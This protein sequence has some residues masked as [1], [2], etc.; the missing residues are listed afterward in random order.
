MGDRQKTKQQLLEELA[1]LRLEIAALKQQRAVPLSPQDVQSQAMTE[2][3]QIKQ[4]LELHAIVIRNIAEGICLVRACDGIIVYANP[5]FE[6]MFGYG[7]EEL[8]GQHVSIV[9]YAPDQATAEAVNQTI[10]QAVTQNGEAIYEVHNV[11]KDGTPFWC[12]AI[13]SAFEHPE[14]GPVFVAVQQDITAQRQAEEKLR[15]SLREKEVLLKE[16]H[17]RV[18]NNLQIVDSLLT[19]QARRTDDPR[20]RSI[21]RD[22]QSRI[23][24]IAL[25]HEKLYRSVDLANIN[26]ARYIQDLSTHLFESYNIDTRQIKLCTRIEKIL[27]D[28]EKAIPCGLI[29]NELIS[30][31]L[32]HAFPNGQTGEIHVELYRNRQLPPKD[33]F[34]YPLI[35][36]VWDNGIG[37][38]TTFD[39]TQTRS[40]GLTL[41]QGLVDQLEGTLTLDRSQGTGFRICF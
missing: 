8:N 34:H 16:I 7:P 28:I 2:Q 4:T 41:V 24:S 40:L 14:Y 23:T 21:L 29:I 33:K 32:K 19:M 5:K 25:V 30:N 12:R 37:L 36:A 31:A 3:L 39:L 1:A 18:K 22:S 17:H 26:F 11:R 27:L 38:P 13:A 35:L 9:N 20:T 6:Q 10:T 15:T